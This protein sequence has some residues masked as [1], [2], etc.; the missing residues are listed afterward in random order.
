MNKP[1]GPAGSGY[2]APDIRNLS[3]YDFN[4]IQQSLNQYQ[5]TQNRP[6]G[7]SKYERTQFDR[8]ARQA[9]ADRKG[10]QRGGGYDIEDEYRFMVSQGFKPTAV[11]PTPTPTTTPAATAEPVADSPTTLE[12]SPPPSI[13]TV[14]TSAADALSRQISNM[15]AAYQQSMAA[16]QQQF[17][18]MQAAQEERMAA[19]QVQMQQ[20][21][22]EASAARQLSERPQVLGVQAAT[23]SAGTPMQIAR[24]GVRGAFS[25]GGMRIQSLN[26]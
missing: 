16:Q 23:G 9:K 17:Q 24:R 1:L 14:D 10:V 26:V 11:A 3:A 8:A 4:K 22:N 5:A 20:Q 25:R 7:L 18:Q 15:Q 13:P 2:T 19:L 12:T 21:A 6:S